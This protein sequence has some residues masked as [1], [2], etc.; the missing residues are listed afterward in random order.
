MHWATILKPPVDQEKKNSWIWL[1]EPQSRASDK[2][3][4]N[5]QESPN[6]NILFDFNS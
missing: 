2:S 1:Y 5:K 6:T 4:I 3:N